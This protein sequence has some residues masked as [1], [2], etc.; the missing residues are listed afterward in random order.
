MNDTTDATNSGVTA[1]PAGPDTEKNHYQS[2]DEVEAARADIDQTRANIGETLDAIK[3]KLDPHA[4]MEEAKDRATEA[5]SNVMEKAKDTVHNVVTDVSTHA[6]ET[7]K[8]AVTG[9]VSGVVDEA[10]DAVSG[11]VGTVKG[12]GTTVMDLVKKNPMP[13]AL[14]GIGAVWLYLLNRDQQ[15]S[16][17]SYGSQPYDATSGYDEYNAAERGT[18]DG[19]AHGGIRETLSG[20]GERLSDMAG[21]VREKASHAAEAVGEAVGTAREKV[22]SAAGHTVETAKDLGETV[23][24]IVRNNPMPA[25]LTGAGLTWLVLSQRGQSSVTVHR[26]AGSRF[27]DSRGQIRH[28]PI[29]NGGDDRSEPGVGNWVA[30]KAGDVKERATEWGSE[31]WERTSE[32]TS[33]SMQSLRRS[34]Y[35][36]P[37]PIG[38]A[39]LGIGVA[40]GLLLPQTERENA[41]MGEARDRLA[42]TATEKVRDLTGKVQRVAEETMDTAKETA[43]EAARTEGLS[44]A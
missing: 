23:V 35:E 30:E 14:I 32:M 6:K 22:G 21:T 26:D 42:E 36:N 15:S 13:A 2:T 11:A 41:L 4:L 12:A 16:A 18:Y 3:D 20:A 44:A 43:K 5:A 31:A 37:I 9:A 29:G 17:R 33:S 38:V 24:D 7:A 40:L 34:F 10:R 28:R 8:G 1:E 39:A 25:A 27:Y 19:E